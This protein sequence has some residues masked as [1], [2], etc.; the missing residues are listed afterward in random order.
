MDVSNISQRLNFARLHYQEPDYNRLL[1]NINK[2]LEKRI[3]EKLILLYGKNNVKQCY[4]EVLRILRAHYSYKKPELIEWEKYFDPKNRFTQ[5]DMIL[6]TYGD[7]ITAKGNSPLKALTNV[8]ENHFAIPSTVHILPFFPYS[9]DKGFAVMDYEEVDPDIGTWEDIANLN[10]RFRLMFDAVFNHVSSKSRW[11][12]RYLHRNPDYKDFFIEFK[13]PDEI[14]KEKLN[15]IIRPRTSD[16]LSPFYTQTGL[17]YFWTTFSRDQ[18]DLNFKNPKVLFKMIE[19]LLYYVRRGADILRLDAVTYLWHKIGT[20]SANL[21]QTHTIV[22][23]FRDILD[24]VA[25]CAGIITETN[26]PHQENIAYFGNGND[27]AQMVYNFALAPLVLYTFYTGNSSKLTNW[28]QNLNRISDTAT[29]FNFLDSHDGVSV[30]GAKEILSKSNIKLLEDRVKSHGGLISYKDNGNGTVSPYELNITWY[31]AINKDGAYESQEI[32]YKR[33][34]AS[35]SIALVLMGVPGLYLHGLLGTKNDYEAVLETKLARNINRKVIDKEML[36]E[37]M[38][39]EHSRT[40]SISQ[41]YRPMAIIRSNHRAF[42]PNAKQ[43]VLSVSQS[44][45]AVIRISVDNEETILCITNVT[46]KTHLFQL[47]INNREQYDYKYWHELLSG[48]RFA[49]K[50]GKLRI[51]VEPYEVL[52]LKAST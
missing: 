14:P 31:S 48:R 9:S 42:H 3:K 28:A 47:D 11:F 10:G 46:D 32:R 5:K 16:I 39:D 13:S 20:T 24:A 25:P 35:R 6:I 34:I 44:L 45:F 22:K 38:Q 49:P 8:L 33:F 37:S 2:K 15:M 40:H 19:I 17:R 36:I 52:W 4:D 41:Y 26:V 1:L 21:E 27:E 43:I 18:V 23:L 50:E 7:L 51:N 30:Q 29:Y 12:H